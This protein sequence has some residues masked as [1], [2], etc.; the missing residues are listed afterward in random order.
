VGT[1]NLTSLLQGSLYLKRHFFN[2][3]VESSIKYALVYGL[4]LAIEV[5]RKLI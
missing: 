3:I 2:S 1:G 4:P 5:W